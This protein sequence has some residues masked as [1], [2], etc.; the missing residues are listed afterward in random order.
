MG[1]YEKMF[2]DKYGKGTI[3]NDID[4]A[5]SKCINKDGSLNSKEFFYFV[6]I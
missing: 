3:F 6:M 5:I 1:E 4:G 2:K